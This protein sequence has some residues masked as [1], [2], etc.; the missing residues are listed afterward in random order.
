MLAG[1]DIDGKAALEPSAGKGD[2]VAELLAAGAS[3]VLACENDDA[4][5]GVLL[6]WWGED[7]RVRFVKDDFLQLRGEDISHIGAIVM[8][9]PFSDAAQHILHAFDIAPGGCTVV[10][11]CNGDSYARNASP[12][13]D[14]LRDTVGAHGVHAK[15]GGAFG[16]AERKTKVP[17]TMLTLVKDAVEDPFAD[18][19]LNDEDDIPAGGTAQGLMPYNAVRDIVNRYVEACRLFGQVDA[20]SKKINAIAKYSDKREGQHEYAPYLPITFGARAADGRI[21]SNV[22]FEVYCKQL[23]KYNWDVIFHK[24]N[25]KRYSTTKLRERL[26]AFVEEQGNKPFT[27]RNIYA[28]L[29]IVV[30][31]HGQRMEQAMVEAFEQIC[32]FSAE[33]STAGEKWKTNADYMVNRRFI[34][35]WMC[36]RRSYGYDNPTVKLYSDACHKFDDIVKVLCHITGRSYESIPALHELSGSQWGQWYKWGFFRIRFHKKD[37]VHCEFLDEDVW[38]AFNREV[39]RIKGWALPCRASGKKGRQQDT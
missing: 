33:N 17:M 35:P 4:L 39:A 1:L 29:D 21:A 7:R 26:A 24:L 30:Q 14:R 6:S 8:N 27:M 28:V 23:Q 32:S 15:M 37:T 36:T 18:Y 9:P 38:Y 11:L 25:M 19:F 22:T 31:T 3:Q 13:W 34:V 16:D 5:R 10:A 12:L 2:I 20:L